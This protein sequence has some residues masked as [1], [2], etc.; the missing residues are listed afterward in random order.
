[1]QAKPYANKGVRGAACGAHIVR[2]CQ[3]VAVC[4]RFRGLSPCRIVTIRVGWHALR[5]HILTIP[6]TAR[7]HTRQVL[8]TR[9]H[10]GRRKCAAC[11][12]LACVCGTRVRHAGTRRVAYACG[13]QHVACGVWRAAYDVPHA[14]RGVWRAAR[15]PQMTA[16]D[17]KGRAA[18]GAHV[19]GVRVSR[20]A[21]GVRHAARFRVAFALASAP[22]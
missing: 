7:W 13:V 3:V 21:G 19:W 10:A 8:A 5:W 17:S 11:G 20:A 9:W 15:A 16:N 2:F 4:V 12:T 18:C 22:W 1:M 6:H 14:A